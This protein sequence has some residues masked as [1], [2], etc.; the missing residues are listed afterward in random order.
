MTV[1]EQLLGGFRALWQHLT[2]LTPLALAINAALSLLIAIIAWLA[3]WGLSWLM[4]YG[5]S[6][7]PQHDAKQKAKQAMRYTRGLILLIV[8]I[9][10]ILNIFSVWGFDLYGWASQG[11]GERLTHAIFAIFIVVTI[12]AVA[13]ETAGIFITWFINRAS[14]GHGDGRRIAQFQT[15]GPIVRRTLQAIILGLGIITLL[16]QVGVQIGPLLAGAGVVG[17]AVGFGAQTLVKDF[18]TGFFLLIE[19]VVAI[20]DVVT[21]QDSTG[22]VENMTLRYI[23]LRDYDGTLHVFPYGEAQVIHN[24][25]KTFSFYVFDLPVAATGTDLDKAFTIVKD[26]ADAMQ[27]DP[28]YGPL[29]LEPIHLS[30]VDYFSDFGTVLKARIK[31][32]PQS[33]WKIGREFNLRV[34]KAF[35]AAG[36]AAGHKGAY[37]AT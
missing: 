31:T 20:G 25:T 13:F 24:L 21:I 27:K 26:T 5:A 3:A 7:I 32:D 10:A 19:D 18:F 12:T 6:R 35:D 15:F 2:S 11:M 8:A 23:S 17:I 28:E 33:R 30:G 4:C 37:V 9:I 36:I 14:K 34:K 22:T 1:S 16:G 29:I